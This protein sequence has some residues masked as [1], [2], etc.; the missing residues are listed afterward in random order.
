MQ[1]WKGIV[2]VDGLTEYEIDFIAERDSFYMAT[3]GENN[4]PY[5]QHRGGP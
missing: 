1:E 4:F 3:M 2:I 5:I